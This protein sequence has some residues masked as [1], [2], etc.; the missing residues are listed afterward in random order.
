MAVVGQFRAAKNSRITISGTPLNFASW[1]LTRAATD[2]DTNTFE[3]QGEDQG[4]IGIARTEYSMGGN[5]DAG[6][7][8]FNSPPGIFPRDNL[9]D[10]KLYENVTDNVFNDIPLSRVLS[11]RNGAKLDGLVTFDASCKSNGGITL[12]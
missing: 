5:W 10:T 3:D 2:L 11:A 12:A 7:P 8:P 1:D 9:P 4:T 6:A